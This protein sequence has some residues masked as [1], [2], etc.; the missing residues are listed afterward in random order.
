MPKPQLKLSLEDKNLL[1]DV[2][3]H[4]GLKPLLAVLDAEAESIE[5]ELLSAN[6]TDEREL[7]RLKSR[8]DGARKLQ[9]CFERRIKTLR[10]KTN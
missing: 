7:V 4:E 9:D 8:A 3:A 6:S 10:S 2:L 1:M 5:Y